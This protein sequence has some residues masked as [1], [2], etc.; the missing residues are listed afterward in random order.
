M[1]GPSL[2]PRQH[3]SGAPCAF[4]GAFLQPEH[5]QCLVGRVVELGRGGQ[6]DAVKADGVDGMRH[7]KHRD[8]GEW[9]GVLVGAAGGG[10]EGIVRGDE[11]VD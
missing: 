7:A 11:L 9:V 8:V 5:A 3:P 6:G 10:V 2:F 1:P 4:A